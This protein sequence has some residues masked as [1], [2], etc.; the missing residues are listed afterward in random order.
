MFSFARASVTDSD[1]VAVA[2]GGVSI[3]GVLV[4]FLAPKHANRMLLSGKLINGCALGSL[5]DS[6]VIGLL[7][8]VMIGMYVSYAGGY[9]AEVVSRQ[10]P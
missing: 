8:H 5:I 4:Q 2:G 3:V 1:D 10:P 9:C 6:E 7:K